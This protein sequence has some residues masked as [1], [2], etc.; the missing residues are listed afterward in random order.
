MLWLIFSGPLLHFTFHND[1]TTCS[2]FV[3]H[4]WDLK[5]GVSEILK[6]CLKYPPTPYMVL[7]HSFLILSEKWYSPN[8]SLNVSHMAFLKVV[9]NWWS[10]SWQYIP[11]CI[12][13]K[14]IF[15]SLDKLIPCIFSLEF[16]KGRREL[17]GY[18]GPNCTVLLTWFQSVC[19]HFLGII[20]FSSKKIIAAFG[21]KY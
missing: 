13:S 3:S 2:W 7:C 8:S 1:A 20:C 9:Y 16:Q 21:R 14:S 4:L 12:V 5:S 15:Y 18:F 10:L 6:L 17:E 19:L 11:L